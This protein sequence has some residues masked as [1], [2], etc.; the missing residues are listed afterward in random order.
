M[1]SHTDHTDHTDPYLDRLVET[2]S[3]RQEQASQAAFSGCFIPS[4]SPLVPPSPSAPLEDKLDFVVARAMYFNPRLSLYTQ[5]G[6]E[7]L[8]TGEELLPIT[9][10]VLFKNPI[11]ALARMSLPADIA[12]LAFMRLISMLPRASSSLIEI[13]PTLVWDKDKGILRETHQIISKRVKHRRRR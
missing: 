6:E 10:N 4:D 8:F 5:G 2:F 11:T 7:M 9:A 1:V 12:R 3:E 13:S